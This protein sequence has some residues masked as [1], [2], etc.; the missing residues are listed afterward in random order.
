MMRRAKLTA[1]EID[2]YLKLVATLPMPGDGGI[3]PRGGQQRLLR[4]THR[5]E[6]AQSV[7]PSQPGHAAPRPHNARPSVFLM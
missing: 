3:K 6:P 1:D 4:P 7:H 2:S 5:H